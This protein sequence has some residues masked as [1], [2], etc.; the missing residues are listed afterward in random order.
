MKLNINEWRKAKG[1]TQKEAA[2]ACGVHV[3][4]YIAWERHIDKMPVGAV[5]KLAERIGVPI[6]D[7]F[8]G[9]PIN[10]R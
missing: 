1:V 6:S 4:T 7:V 9:D 10:D 3:N 5:R 2:D 8:L